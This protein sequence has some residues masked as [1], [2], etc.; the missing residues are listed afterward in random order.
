MTS[1]TA[2]ESKTEMIRAASGVARRVRQVHGSASPPVVAWGGGEPSALDRLRTAG[3]AGTRSPG[4]RHAGESTSECRISIDELM[5]R[6]AGRCASVPPWGRERCGRVVA[7]ER[8]STFGAG[9]L[10]SSSRQPGNGGDHPLALLGRD[11]SS[12]GPRRWIA[13]RIVSAGRHSEGFLVTTSLHLSRQ[14][15]IP[16][17]GPRRHPLPSHRR[18]P[19]QP[20][21]PMVLGAPA[22]RSLVRRLGMFRRARDRT[23]RTR[24]FLPRRH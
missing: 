5:P 9:R 10:E 21:T 1:C 4:D 3:Q 12:G 16:R 23:F 13:R 11:G 24:V 8:V 6:S 18:D 20:H 22:G 19:V 14:L 17:W 2:I 7:N 15:S